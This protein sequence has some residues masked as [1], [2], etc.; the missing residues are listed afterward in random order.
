MFKRMLFMIVG[1]FSA[2]TLVSSCSGTDKAAGLA[3]GKTPGESVAEANR[4]PI[5]LAITTQG[6][7]EEEF[8]AT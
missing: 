8:L 2:M 7:E 3:D 1:L 4:E 5:E 6:A